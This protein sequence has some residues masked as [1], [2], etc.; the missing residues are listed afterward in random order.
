[1][2]SPTAWVESLP[3]NRKKAIHELTQGQEWTDKL[4]EILRGSENIECDPISLDGIVG[5]IMGMFDNTLTII[6]SCSSNKTIKFPTNMDEQNSMK[7]DEPFQLQTRCLD[8]SRSSGEHKSTNCSE[9]LR[10]QTNYLDSSHSSNEQKSRTCDESSR[11]IIP[12]KTKRGCYKRKN[13]WASTQI[14]SIL[15]DD[16]HAWR[17]YGQKKILESKHERSYYRCTYKVDQGCQATKQVQMIEDEPPLY[18]ITYMKSH[19]CKNLQRAPQII[20]DSPDPR[21]TSILVNF[22]AKGITGNK[23]VNPLFHIMKHESEDSSP[24]LSNWRDNKSTPSTNC[25][26]LDLFAVGSQVPLESVSNSKGLDHEAFLWS[27][28]GN[29]T[30]SGT[31]SSMASTQWHEM[32]HMFGS[33]DFNDFP[34]SV[35]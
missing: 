25:L 32:D 26:S 3:V 27:K 1:M 10:L 5:Q 20:L 23:Q 6:G 30:S 28:H 33:N 19:T 16:G 8:S 2:E 17:K 21:D 14:T 15:T 7:S 4:R 13:S 35:L 18:K 9:S 29:M 24:S 12:G 34:F 11:M 31:Y 22:G